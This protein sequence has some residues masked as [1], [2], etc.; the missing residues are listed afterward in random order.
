M[1]TP[2]EDAADHTVSGAVY[3]METE[4]HEL[5]A[6][7]ERAELML[8]L[9]VAKADRDYWKNRFEDHESNCED[10]EHQASQFEAQR[11]VFKRQCEEMRDK[12]DDLRT[13]RD[14]HLARVV[15]LEEHID[16]ETGE[17]K[18][19]ARLL[20]EKYQMLEE[21]TM[22]KAAID[23]LQG[24]VTKYKGFY[25][26]RCDRVLA[27]EH[28]NANLT[29]RIRE[30]ET[31][32][33]TLIEQLSDAKRRAKKWRDDCEWV[34]A[35]AAVLRETVEARDAELER[36]RGSS[37]ASTTAAY[38]DTIDS[39]RE[40]VAELQRDVRR[41]QKHDEDT[42]QALITAQ[43]AN[44][45]LQKELNDSVPGTHKL[46]AKWRDAETR[47]ASQASQLGEWGTYAMA[48]TVSVVLSNILR[49]EEPK[50]S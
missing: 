3:Q 34:K 9:D 31:Q 15:E 40:Q 37:V 38:R 45:R 25:Q 22:L 2:H 43:N 17:D 20:A 33:D 5:G 24:E 44:R 47:R 50:S 28:E 35:D 42:C 46:L 14:E 18:E 13:E 16:P 11:D 23:R 29:Q 26:Q 48:T 10:W 6:D 4:L 1:S 36:L 8:K 32:V 21:R 19:V 41:I 7:Q 39:L 12:Y 27:L 30:L 49:G